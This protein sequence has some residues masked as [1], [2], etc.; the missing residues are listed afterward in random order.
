M[1]TSVKNIV[2]GD[3]KLDVARQTVTRR[4]NRLD[5]AG[6]SF[7]LLQVLAD[8]WPL[9]VTRRE[10]RRQVWGEV[11]VSDDTLRQRIRLLRRSLGETDYVSTVKGVG[12]RLNQPVKMASSFR[13][14]RTLYVAASLVALGLV[15]FG[16]F[17]TGFTQDLAH[18]VR[19]AIKH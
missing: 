16:V 3:L 6:L 1:N 2:I 5:V 4:G 7:R 11:V 12:Y 15:A 13:H 8:Q 17:S 18:V 9:A 19:H 14:H 10:L